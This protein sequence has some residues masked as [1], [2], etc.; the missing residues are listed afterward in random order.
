MRNTVPAALDLFI[1]FP[2]S[3]S[4]YICRYLYLSNHNVCLHLHLSIIISISLSLYLNLSISS[5]TGAAA[6]AATA[7]DTY[8]SIS[9]FLSLYLCLHLSIS[10]FISLSVDHPPLYLWCCCCCCCCLSPSLYLSISPLYLW[11]CWCSPLLLLWARIPSPVADQQ[12]KWRSAKRMHSMAELAIKVPEQLCNECRILGLKRHTAASQENPSLGVGQGTLL[13]RGSGFGF[14]ILGLG[15]L[16][17]LAR[18][19]HHADELLRLFGLFR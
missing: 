15:F 10:V 6:D 4:L 2:L 13:L 14:R 16:H 19:T 17:L 18:A 11:C 9:T 12:P 3:L 7:N 1:S 5:A 8:L